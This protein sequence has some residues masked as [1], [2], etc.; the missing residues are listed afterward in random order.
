[1][2]LISLYLRTELY[3]STLAVIPVLVLA[4]RLTCPDSNQVFEHCLLSLRSIHISAN[5][6]RYICACLKKKKKKSAVYSR[7]SL[8]L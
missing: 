7:L 3:F 4:H 6:N 1:M 8:Y 2:S 5:V